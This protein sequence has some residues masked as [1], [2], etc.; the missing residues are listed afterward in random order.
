[1]TAIQDTAPPGGV[2]P[3]TSEPADPIGRA[4]LLLKN[5]GEPTRGVIL[6][7]LAEGERCVEDIRRVVAA[8]S[9][10]GSTQPAVS[11]HLLRMEALGILT[12]RRDAKRRFYA[13]SSTGV[14]LATAVRGIM[15]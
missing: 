1:M 11:H 3:T 9:V 6:V 14:R 4:S 7:T 5:V 13:L 2:E 15:D 12:V 10:R 8:R